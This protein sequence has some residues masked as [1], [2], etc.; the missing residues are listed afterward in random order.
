MMEK[1][2]EAA[3]AAAHPTEAPPA[4]P[5]SSLRATPPIRIIPSSSNSSSSTSSG[6]SDRSSSSSNGSSSN[7]SSN[8]LTSADV[9]GPAGD[10]EEELKPGAY[11]SPFLTSSPLGSVLQSHAA[12]MQQQPQA[13]GGLHAA[14]EG[15]EG[16]RQRHSLGFGVRGGGES[17]HGL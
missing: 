1:D 17:L 12:K 16:G 6:S 13:L 7:S 9:V 5:P 2:D 8:I 11:L 4:E 14:D 15:L 10:R 3:T